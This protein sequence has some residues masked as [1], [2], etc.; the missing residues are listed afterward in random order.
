MYEVAVVGSSGFLGAATM[1]AFD[2]AGCSAV[3]F[4]LE[5][6]MF[7]DGV[8]DEAAEGVRTVVWCASRINPLLAAEHP[9]L[10]ARDAA[11][12]H[13]ALEHF[14]T[15]PRPP[16]VIAFSSGGTVY[17]PPAA[18]PYAE[19]MEASPVNAYGAAKLAIERQLRESGLESVSLRIAN[20][21]GPGQRPAPGQGVLAHWMEAVLSGG[22]VHLYGD[23]TATRDYVFVD[24]IARAVV[25]AHAAEAPPA[26]VNIGTGVPTTLDELL[27]ALEF[28]VVPARFDTVRHPARFTDTA[29]S[30]LDV[31][32]AASALGWRPQVSLDAGVAAMWQW[33]ASQ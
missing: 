12:L 26:I 11:D 23:A 1:K 32:L 4:T 5:R 17:G 19:S 2:V 14:L 21:F 28:A 30:T 15:W 13:E 8:L 7:V 6:P 16:R 9:E 24:D 3:G 29:H 10:V 22:E 31:T 27:Q 18:P 33:R 20:A 25:A